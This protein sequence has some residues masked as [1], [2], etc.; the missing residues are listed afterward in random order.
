MLKFQTIESLDFAAKMGVTIS[1]KKAKAAV[2]RN[3]YKRILKEAYRL[4]KSSLIEYLEANQKFL[5]C[6][7]VYVH[8][9]PQK[10]AYHTIAA[11]MKELLEKL[12]KKLCAAN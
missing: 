7:F 2:D 4:Q 10:A 11:E 12:N 6:F 1:K 8:I 9:P 3:F 5:I